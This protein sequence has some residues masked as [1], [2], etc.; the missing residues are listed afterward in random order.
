MTRFRV[1]VISAFLIVVLFLSGCSCGA[2][3]S[4]TTSH[5][6]TGTITLGKSTDVTS[7]V[8]PAGG[9]TLTVNAPDSPVDGLEIDVPAGAY[10]DSVN[11][12]ISTAEVKKHTFGKDFNP[13]TPLIIIDNGG[14]YAN[15]IINVTIPVQ[16]PEG[17]F[18]MAFYYDAASGRLEGIP[19]LELTADSLTIATRHFSKIVVSSIPESELNSDAEVNT[20]FEPGTDDWQFTN[21]GSFIAPGGHCAGQSITALWYYSQMKSAGESS[22]YG[23]YNEGT[24]DFWF[25]DARAYRFASVIQKD[26]DWEA[27][28]AR[29]NKIKPKAQADNS[30]VWK[31]FVYAMKLSGEPQFIY[32]QN[33]GIGGAHAMIVYGVSGG[34]LQIA[35]PNYPGRNDREI[36]FEDGEFETYNSGDNAQA[37][38]DG[39]GK[40]YDLMLYFGTSSLV[41]FNTIAARWSEFEEGTIGND[42]FPS[43]TVMTTDSNGNP[44]ELEDGFTTNSSIIEISIDAG[45]QDCANYVYR[46]EKLLSPTHPGGYDYTLEPGNN[47]FGIYVV[48]NK[49]GN[50]KYVDFKRINVKLQEYVLTITPDYVEGETGQTFT[51]AADTDVPLDNATYEWIVDGTSY[52]VGY[53]T[54]FVTD[55]GA[56]GSHII[57]VT[58]YV[59]GKA[60][61]TAAAEVVIPEE[62]ETTTTTT[63]TTTKTTTTT[64]TLSQIEMLRKNIR[65]SCSV[66]YMRGSY[67]IDI[68]PAGTMPITWE[69]NSFSGTSRYTILTY[70]VSG[71]FSDDGKTLL[72]LNFRKVWDTGYEMFFTVTDLPVEDVRKMSWNYQTN[73]GTVI[74]KYVTSITSLGADKTVQYTQNDIAVSDYYKLSVD[75]YTYE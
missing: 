73:D 28:E 14:E 29:Y 56:A 44:V 11:Y 49:N 63:T 23:R 2:P 20:G 10:P 57:E 62:E 68:S 36:W 40:A 61:Q 65:M 25:D 34:A 33:T 37:I 69:G 47:E 41:D 22:L 32:I 21:F 26:V 43:Y 45:T 19:T 53:D 8:I 16:I 42:L 50:W 18:A 51:F 67:G 39:K 64:A 72:E 75:F 7:Q 9:G 60:M 30:I 71:R 35:D 70:T 3:V 1:V 15:D 48:G 5:G 74:Q 12:S 46:E 55:F 38:L 58:L 31:Q 24:R 17:N 54:I 52:G 6:I 4:T 27:W 66:N 59:G 13:V